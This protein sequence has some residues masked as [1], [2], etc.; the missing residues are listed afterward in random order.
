VAL[1]LIAAAVFGLGETIFAP[2]WS[3]VVNEL[4][5]DHLRGR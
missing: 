1:L 4:A 5:P 3:T 2:V